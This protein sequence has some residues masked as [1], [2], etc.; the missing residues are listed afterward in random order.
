VPRFHV[1]WSRSLESRKRRSSLPTAMPKGPPCY[2]SPKPNSAAKLTILW[3]TGPTGW[4]GVDRVLAWSRVNEFVYAA[5]RIIPCRFRI[6]AL[7]VPRKCN[8]HNRLPR[9]SL[10][11]ANREFDHREQGNSVFKTAICSPV[12]REIRQSALR[13]GQNP[14]DGVLPRA[15]VYSAAGVLRYPDLCPAEPRG[16]TIGPSPQPHARQLVITD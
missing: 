6:S 5:Q 11:F 3:L 16:Y 15:C 13:A 4:L 7:S 2:T 10:F 14:R 1:P 8:Y 12:I 9:N